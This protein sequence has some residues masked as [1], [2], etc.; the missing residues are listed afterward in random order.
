MTARDGQGPRAPSA[1]WSGSPVAVHPV[2]AAAIAAITAPAERLA[3]LAG[4]HFAAV[5][6]A[7]IVPVEGGKFLRL[8]GLD[9]GQ[10]HGAV[11]VDVEAS[12]HAIRHAPDQLLE[13]V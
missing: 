13:H 11:A 4:A 6:L 2:M 3:V 8:L 9:L 12:L 7:V 10:R 5:E 1:P